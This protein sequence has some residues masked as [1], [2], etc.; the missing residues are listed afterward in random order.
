[1]DHQLIMKVV[2]EEGNHNRSSREANNQSWTHGPTNSKI[3]S[4]SN[5]SQT[6]HWIKWDQM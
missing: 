4:N 3:S 2:H 1:M 6:W 5:K